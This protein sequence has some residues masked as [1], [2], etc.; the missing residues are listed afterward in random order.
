MSREFEDKPQSRIESLPKTHLI[1]DRYPKYTTKYIKDYYPKYTNDLMKKWAK[2]Y[3]PP[4]KIHGGHG[5]TWRDVPHHRSS[6]KCKW[7][8]Q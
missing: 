7:K 8:R 3:I 6:G 5:S 2:V 1:K 4:E